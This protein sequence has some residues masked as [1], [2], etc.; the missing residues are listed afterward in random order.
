MCMLKRRRVPFMFLLY[1]FTEK[2][3]STSRTQPFLTPYLPS[4][5]AATLRFDPHSNTLKV[6][7]SNSHQKKHSGRKR[8]RERL[9]VLFG[10]F[11]C[12]SKVLRIV[13]RQIKAN[14]Q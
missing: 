5:L 12:S 11:F 14:Q 13:N 6:E 7:E 2:K 3:N 1:I 9:N 8:R 10:V 4:S